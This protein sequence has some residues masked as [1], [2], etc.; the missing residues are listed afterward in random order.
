M[1]YSPPPLFK[2][3]APARVKVTVFALL[4]IALLVADARF[5][6]LT[7]VRQVA[8]TVLYPFQVAALAPRDQPKSGLRRRPH[9]RDRQSR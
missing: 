6:A 9:C 7:T 3:G 2:Q 1:E 8:A 4:S 5:H